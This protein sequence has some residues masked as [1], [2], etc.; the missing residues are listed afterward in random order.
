[1]T[2]LDVAASALSEE[3]FAQWIRDHLQ[4]RSF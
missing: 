4:P 3:A 2:M 1:L